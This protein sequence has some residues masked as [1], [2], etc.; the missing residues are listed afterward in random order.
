[1]GTSETA[2]VYLF[3]QRGIYLSTSHSTSLCPI[4]HAEALVFLSQIVV[5]GSPTA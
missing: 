4:D 2:I 1:M 3:S 5:G